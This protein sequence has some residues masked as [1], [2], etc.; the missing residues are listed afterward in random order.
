MSGEL[1]GKVRLVVSFPA[2]EDIV[3]LA[4]DEICFCGANSVQVMRRMNALIADLIPQV[5]EERRPDLLRWQARVSA[6]IA[7][8][9][10]GE[11]ERMEAMKEDRQGLGVPRQ[12][13]RGHSIA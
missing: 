4:L 3:R 12:R 1:L 7:R 5:P 11:E 2:W 9:F 10:V 13:T 8:S 6:T